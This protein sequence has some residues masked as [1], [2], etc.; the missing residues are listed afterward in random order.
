M[1][2]SHHAHREHQVSHRRVANL[3]KGHPEGAMQHNKSNA[4]SKV[5]SKSA[6]QNHDDYAC[7]GSTAPKR[8]ARGGK[9]KKADGG[10]ADQVARDTKGD[11][12]PQKSDARYGDAGDD[13]LL[14]NEFGYTLKRNN[15]RAPSRIT[16]DASTA[17]KGPQYARGGKVKAKSGHQTNI[18]IVVPHRGAQE[19]MA[20]APPGGAL[21]MPAP[22]GPAPGMPPGAAGPAPGMP[23]GMP[24]HKRGGRVGKAHGGSIEGEAREKNIKGWSKRAKD[25]SYARGGAASGV[26]REEKAEK[27]KRK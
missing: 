13:N 9:V 16:G 17:D 7:G 23:P 12:V 15:W 26:G 21:P 19:P 25:N 27:Q 10:T 3:L 1:A 18:A 20:G 14:G 2:H 11:S 24:M 5:T 8:F 22:G 6:A 4:F